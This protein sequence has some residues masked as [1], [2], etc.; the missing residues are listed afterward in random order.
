VVAVLA[1]ILAAR[2]AYYGEHGDLVIY[3][4]W[5]PVC[6]GFGRQI[7]YHAGK[8]WPI[9]ARTVT[10]RLGRLQHKTPSSGLGLV[11]HT[12]LLTRAKPASFVTSGFLD[13]IRQ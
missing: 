2:L 5:W 4:S 7:G 1:M 13:V 11:N 6:S 3:R 10:L 8:H 12:L 9:Y